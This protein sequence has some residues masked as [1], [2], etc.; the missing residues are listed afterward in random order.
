MA[1]WKTTMPALPLARGVPVTDC[2]GPGGAGTVRGVVIATE[3]EDIDP[4]IGEPVAWVVLDD[5]AERATGR[6][7]ESAWS[8]WRVDLDDPQ[9]YA[10]AMRWLLRRYTGLPSSF[11]EHTASTFWLSVVLAG[12]VA[13]ADGQKVSR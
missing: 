2:T 8:R 5:W 12:V 11:A 13:E 10:Y 9:G 4:A 3:G 1:H 6:I 7:I